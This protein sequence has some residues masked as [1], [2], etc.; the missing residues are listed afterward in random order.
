MR[1]GRRAAA[2]GRGVCAPRGRTKPREGESGV[3]GGGI[4]SGARRARP[5][6]RARSFTQGVRACA[7]A[8][9]R[10]CV[11]VCVCVCAIV[12]K[13][14][15]SL[16]ICFTQPRRTQNTQRTHKQPATPL[17]LL[18]LSL[19]HALPQ[20]TSTSKKGGGGAKKKQGRARPPPLRLVCKKPHPR[21][22]LFSPSHHHPEEKHTTHAHAS[23]RS[24]VKTLRFVV[25]LPPN[26][27]TPNAITPPSAK[28]TQEALRPFFLGL[29]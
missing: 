20:R 16:L 13:A 12:S 9:V 19:P 18:L 17:H 6:P 24:L 26:P 4:F 14:R 28:T 8:R 1:G 23:A 2:A 5:R 15:R 29:S 27:S 25:G 21:K 7:R 3:E 10:V 22:K 11:C